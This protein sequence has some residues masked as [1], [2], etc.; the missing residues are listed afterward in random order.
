[1]KGAV[2]D[3]QLWMEVAGKNRLFGPL[4][5]EAYRRAATEI[6]SCRTQQFKDAAE[7]VRG[8]GDAGKDVLIEAYRDFRSSAFVSKSAVAFWCD[9]TYEGEA[10]MISASL[11]AGSDGMTDQDCAKVFS[12]M[13]RH[14]TDLF[15]AFQV[16]VMGLDP[17]TGPASSF[18]MEE[19]DAQIAKD[20]DSQD[21][22]GDESKD[23]A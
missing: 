18:T 13:T 21:S 10:F 11:R 16:G 5:K 4:G 3:R 14:Q 20:A 9:E 1:M 2:G 17:R 22:S 7:I 23:A 6:R 15:A 8:L 19:I 12:G